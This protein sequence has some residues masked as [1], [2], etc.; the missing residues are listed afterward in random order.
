MSKLLLGLL[1]SILLCQF[2]YPAYGD[3][4]A[5]ALHPTDP[6]ILYLGSRSGLSRTSLGGEGSTGQGLDTYSPRAIVVSD[7]NHDLVYAGTYEMGV[8]RSDDG[9][10]SWEAAN[11][12]ITDLR[13]RAMVI[14]PQDDQTV[15]A[16]TDG[17]GVF[18]TTNGGRLWKAVNRGLI[19]KVIR[20]LVID[21]D[22]P[23]LL[24]A[25]TWHGVYKTTDAGENWQ[26]DP[27]GLYDVDVCALALDPTNSKI[28][29]AGTQPRG[30]FRSTNGGKT[31]IPG[32]NP[33]TEKI[34]ALTIDPANPGHIY[35]GTRAGV[36]VSKDQGDTFESAGL[37]WSNRTWCLVFDPKTNPPTLY[38][39][40]ISFAGVFKTTNGGKWWDMIKL[41][42]SR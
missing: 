37:R 16:G 36:F 14:D 7:S 40:G 1:V 2:P 31:W 3:V 26:A 39:G 13:I 30:V 25:G 5:I 24:Y 23:N 27:E 12:G 11:A 42:R 32:A 9:A 33:L 6:D 38:Y 34:D 35:V 4:Q 41:P 20:S 10:K 17:T 21:P 15:Y 18:K 29:Y 8:F 19:D 22:N 28:L